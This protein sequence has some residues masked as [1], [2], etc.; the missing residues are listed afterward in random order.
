MF[1]PLIG[2]PFRAK[3]RLV[4]GAYVPVDRD[5]RRMAA[6]REKVRKSQPKPR[7]VAPAPVVNAYTG[8]PVRPEVQAAFDQDLRTR[9]NRRLRKYRI[10]TA[11]TRVGHTQHRGTSRAQRSTR[12]V[13]TVA[14]SSGDPPQSGEDDPEHHDV[15]RRC[16]ICGV[17]FAPEARRHKKTCGYLCRKRLE[18]MRDHLPAQQNGIGNGNGNGRRI[19]TPR[20]RSRLIDQIARA[21]LEREG[22]YQ[23]VER[24]ERDL[25]RAR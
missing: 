22:G 5:R 4:D 20:E 25:E 7:P 21:R 23:R 24:G 12:R 1:A 11:P 16:A 6:H 8:E 14:S 10:A 9:R 18:R 17:P 3:Y 19:L 15:V 13:R 2:K